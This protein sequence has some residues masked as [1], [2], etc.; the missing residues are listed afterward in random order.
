MTSLAT[1][2]RYTSLTENLKFEI[3]TATQRGRQVWNLISVN[4]KNVTSI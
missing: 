4:I 2:R 3:E 1:S